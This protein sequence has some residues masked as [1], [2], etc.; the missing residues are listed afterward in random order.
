M[1][2]GVVALGGLDLAPGVAA[3]HADAAA[4]MGVAEAARIFLWGA[5]LI[6]VVVV[7]VA[8]A[9]AA[10]AAAVHVIAAG[11]VHLETSFAGVVLAAV[12]VGGGAAGVIA[13]DGPEGNVFVAEVDLVLSMSDSV[14]EAVE[15]GEL[16][17]EFVS[18]V[19]EPVQQAAGL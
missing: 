16:A 4:L 8:A 2:L 7:V 11:N 6:A 3:E 18:V 15:G 1:F 14:A 5:S 19:A 9:A 10:A 17:V 13:D 12:A